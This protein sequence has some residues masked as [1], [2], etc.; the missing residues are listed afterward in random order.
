MIMDCDKYAGKCV[1]GRV[2]TLETR[3][4][5]VD[6]K[7]IE[8][9]ETYMEELG[10]TGRRTAIYDEIT[11]KL[12]EGQHVR[13]DQN[14]ILD[15]NGLH[16]EDV[17]IEKMMEQLDSPDVLIAVGAGTI[18]DFGRY[19]AY[20]LGIPFVAIP[21]LAS[22]DGF[23]ANICSA[24]L[25]GQKKST[26]MC[27]PVLVIADLDI[28]KGAP[29][30][31]VAS[32]INDILAKYISMLDWR[33][34]KLVADEYFCPVVAE[35]ADHALMLMR[36]AADKYAATGVADHEAMT[37]AQMESGLTMQL[38]N[39]SRAA[40]GAEHLMAHIVEMHPPRLEK[41]EGIHGECVGVGTF[42]CIKEYHRLAGLTPKAK[43]FTPISEDWVREKFGDRLTPGIMKENENDVLATFD[44]QNIVDHWP[45]IKAMI[46]ALPSVEEMEALYKACGCKYLPE[47]IGID[48]AIADEVLDMSAAIRNRL[49]LIRM[50]RVL[51]FS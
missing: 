10:L 45:E 46:D 24:I 43:P 35:L 37:M 38:L 15:P 33:I 18:M 8:N 17:L 41:A 22:S 20:K 29:Q 19:P 4:V 3:K 47:H 36:G 49:T 13:A 27:A 30:R 9:F 50:K 6:E 39:H 42:A 2:H 14:I 12:T 11:W 1:C 25:N 21:T 44:P 40:S 16:A 51:D 5:V 31:L 23:T 28:I 48:P 32:G 7:A 26:P 34:S